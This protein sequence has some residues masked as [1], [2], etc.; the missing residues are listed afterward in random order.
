MMSTYLDAIIERKH[1]DLQTLKTVRPLA[2]VRARA[3]SVQPALNF[4]QALRE[5]GVQIIA[6]VKKAS[7]SKGDMAPDLDP[8]GIARTYAAHGAAAIS[9]LTEEP[10]FNGRIDFLD[11]IKNDLGAGSPP[12]LRKDFILEPYQVYESRAHHADGLL[13]IVAVLSDLELQDLLGLTRKLGMEALVEVH[14]IAEALRAVAVGAEV[15]GI[16]NRDLQT[17]ETTIE[18]TRLVRPHIPSDRIV[19]SE[20]GISTPA[21]ASKI[22]SWKVDAL[23]VGEALVTSG[24]PG[25][26]LRELRP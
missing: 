18:T 20:S 5:P 17:F 24:N 15:I 8:V 19:V 26:K 7:P 25:A 10:H 4:K 16:N 21:D 9:V 23:L 3:E 13:L 12:L 2:E 22:A 14:D 6:E 11:A 1:N